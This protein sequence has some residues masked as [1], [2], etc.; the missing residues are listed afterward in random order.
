MSAFLFVGCE[1]AVYTYRY[2]AA[3]MNE[4]QN[5][6]A[7]WIPNNSTPAP[8]PPNSDSTTAG[9]V[10][11]SSEGKIIPLSSDGEPLIINETEY[12]ASNKGVL[13][14][15]KIYVEDPYT[16]QRYY[17]QAYYLVPPSYYFDRWPYHYGYGYRYGYRHRYNHWHHHW[18][19]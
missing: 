4:Y 2:R 6:M 11:E 3:T 19:Y 14:S 9:W 8:L 12:G 5:L 7:S 16:N 17:K 18:G 1:E 15:T 10:L 13:L